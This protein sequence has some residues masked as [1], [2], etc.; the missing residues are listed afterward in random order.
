MSALGLVRTRGE[1][2]LLDFEEA[3]F[4]QCGSE[5]T[6]HWQQFLVTFW[7]R[8]MLTELLPFAVVF[9]S[10]LSADVLWVFLW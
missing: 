8:Y 2:Q 4:V 1:D 10:D 3:G 9:L 7:R 5:Q 6:G